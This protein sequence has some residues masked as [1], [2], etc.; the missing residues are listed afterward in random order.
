MTKLN[1]DWKYFSVFQP[2]WPKYMHFQLSMCMLSGSL[3]RDSNPPPFERGGLEDSDLWK[4]GFGSSLYTGLKPPR[5]ESRCPRGMDTSTSL[6]M[7]A[8]TLQ[9]PPFVSS[10]SIIYD[11]WKGGFRKGGFTSHFVLEKLRLER[12][13]LGQSD[14]TP[15]WKGG[16]AFVYIL[17]TTLIRYWSP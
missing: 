7:Y 13:G 8:W 12:G 2:P 16:L 11:F 1:G 15:F 4:G 3:Y 5:S 10:F 9:T 17:C 14:Q 6:S